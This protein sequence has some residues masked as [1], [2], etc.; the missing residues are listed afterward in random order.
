[1]DPKKSQITIL[2]LLIL[3]EEATSRFYQAF[4]SKFPE[5]KQ[6]CEHLATEE[7]GHANILRVLHSKVNEGK[8]YF[9]ENRFKETAIKSCLD[10]LNDRI[11]EMQHTEK[12]LT[13]MLSLAL[14]M[15]KTVIENKF[16]EVFESDLA[17]FK[18]MLKK[19]AE[20]EQHH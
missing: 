19:I 10:Y 7:T 11:D 20:S 5:H 8:V 1:M 9:T 16:Y 14:D 18:H 17:E 4:A 2:D 3:H 13:E 6:F 15:E 12:T